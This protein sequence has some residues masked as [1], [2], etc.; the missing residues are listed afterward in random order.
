V[1]VDYFLAR[2]GAVAFTLTAVWL[3]SLATSS[4]MKDAALIY[5]MVWVTLY[6]GRLIEGFMKAVQQ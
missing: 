1:T 3:I 6:D 5:V 2:L 4:S